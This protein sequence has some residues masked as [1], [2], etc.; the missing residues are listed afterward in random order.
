MEKRVVAVGKR[1]GRRI[2]VTMEAQESCPCGEQ[3]LLLMEDGNVVKRCSKPGPRC[4]A[5]DDAA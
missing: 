2:V 5:V 4:K 3:M 1:T